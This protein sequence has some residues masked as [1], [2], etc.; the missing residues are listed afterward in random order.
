MVR[1]ISFHRFPG[2]VVSTKPASA[3]YRSF[4]FRDEAW[5]RGRGAPHDRLVPPPQLKHSADAPRKGSGLT[6]R[7]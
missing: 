6:C 5:I 1:W 7:S 2:R 3:E 4:L